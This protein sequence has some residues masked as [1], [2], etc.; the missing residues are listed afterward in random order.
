MR[1]VISSDAHYPNLDADTQVTI[2]TAAALGEAGA[3]VTLLV[4]RL[5]RQR[6]EDI[7]AFYSVPESFCL[8]PIRAWPFPE[9]TFRIEKIFHG[10]VAPLWPAARSADLLHSRNLMALLQAQLTGLRWSYETYRRQAAEKPWLP[11]LTRRLDLSRGMAVTHSEASRADL[12]ELGFAPDAVA[13]AR[14]GANLDFFNP[15]RDR[16]EARRTCGLAETGPIVSY[17]GNI[18]MFKGM[19]ELVAMAKRVP[20]ATFVVV[21]GSPEQVTELERAAAAEGA[22]NVKPVGYRPAAEVPAWL[23]ASDVLLLPPTY[24]NLNPSKIARRFLKPRLPGTPFKIYSYLAAGRP[25]VAADQTINTE[26]LRHEENALLYPPEDMDAAAAAIQRLIDDA[27]LAKR[28]GKA[29][30]KQAEQLTWRHRAEI[31]LAFFERRLSD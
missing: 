16:E 4:P 29:G 7:L 27:R 17:M 5:W 12:I 21:G 8:V 23:F 13:V 11:G 6:V 26:L 30:R 22:S 19:S 20:R 3:D 24:G 25:T 18:Q 15:A 14:P 1:I 2:N 10:L 28:L 31:M 9:S